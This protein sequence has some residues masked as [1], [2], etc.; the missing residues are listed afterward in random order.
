MAEN[1]S[2]GTLSDHPSQQAI[3]ASS[4]TEIEQLRAERD[5]L[6]N[7]QRAI[8]EL[9]GSTRPER[10]LHDIRNVLN[11][12]VLLRSLAGIEDDAKTK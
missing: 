7:R 12:R 1:S 11:E 9:L 6:L 8:M 5:H 10:L 4:P 2:I 3:N